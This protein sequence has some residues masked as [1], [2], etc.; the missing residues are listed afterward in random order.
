[1]EQI[2]SVVFIILGAV[3]YAIFIGSVSSAAMSVNPAGR[4]YT[5][6]IEELKDYIKWKDLNPETQRKLFNYYETKYRGKYFE[7][8][9]LLGDMNESLKS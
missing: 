9:A 7:E 8:D 5:E 4:L 2:A 1:M 6:K 3:L